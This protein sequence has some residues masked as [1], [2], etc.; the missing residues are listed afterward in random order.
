[1]EWLMSKRLPAG[2]YFI[3]D[4]RPRYLYILSDST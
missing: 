3:T 1:M 4:S 2:K